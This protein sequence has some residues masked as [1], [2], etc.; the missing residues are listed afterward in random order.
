MPISQTIHITVL[1]DAR[2]MVETA[3]R[4]LAAIE[5]EPD[6]GAT[7]KIRL[8]EAIANLHAALARLT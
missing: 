7:N 1:R 4:R 5:Q 8:T 6:R 3:A 2:K